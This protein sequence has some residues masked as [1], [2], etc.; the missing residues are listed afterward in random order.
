MKKAVGWSGKLLSLSARITLVKACLASILVYL[1]SF[2]K[3]SKWA[4][5]LLNSQMANCLW[6]DSEENHKYHLANWE[7]VLMCK[8]FGGLG[9]PNLRELNICLLV[10]WLKTYSKD[11][12]KLWKELVDFKY[13]TDHPN[14]LVTNSLGASNF[15]RGFMRAV[16]VATMAYRWKIGDGRKARFWEDCW[17]GSSSL[18][19]QYWPLYRLVNEKNKPIADVWVDQELRFTFRRTLNEHLYNL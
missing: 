16:Q 9:I 1:L 13:R 7:L 19:I 12:D 18:A 6:N 14:I 8:D 4:I 15:F 11:K 10:S 2:L 17:L 3:F 5:K